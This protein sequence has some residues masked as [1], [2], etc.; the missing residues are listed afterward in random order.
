ML[1]GG[2]R[3][4]PRACGHI[5]KQHDGSA[6]TQHPRDLADGLF[7]VEPV[8]RLSGE[9]GIN[10]LVRER[11]RLAGPAERLR[12]GQSDW[13]SRRIGTDGSTATTRENTP[14]STRVSFPVPAPRSTT[15]DDE[16][17]AATR[18]ASTGQPGLPRS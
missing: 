16:G 10:R 6:G 2:G 13:S 7:V 5:P 14:T 3:R 9:N 18:M 8:E 15:S 11:E 1:R 17:S 12:L 4:L